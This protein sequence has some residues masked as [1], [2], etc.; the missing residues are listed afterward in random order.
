MPTVISIPYLLILRK[1]LYHRFQGYFITNVIFMN[2]LSDV[3]MSAS[4]THN[5]Q[6]K[7]IDPL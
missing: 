1:V 7:K 2:E 4:E 6:L 3:G 5:C